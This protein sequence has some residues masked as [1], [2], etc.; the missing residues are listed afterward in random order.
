MCGIAG[1]IA[2]PDPDAGRAAVQRMLSRLTRRG[3]DAEGLQQWP[4]AVL[5]HRRLSIFDLS[6]AGR[7]PMTLP[8]GSVSVVFNGAIY[9]F[10]DLRQQL[11]AKGCHFHSRTDTEIL[12]HG[13]RVWGIEELVRRIR[14]MYAIGLWD[15]AERRLFLLRDRLGVKPLL[16]AERNGR[17]AFASTAPALAAAGF[18]G[19]IDPEA[20]SEYL[21]FGYVTDQRVIYSGLKKLLAGTVLE[22]QPGKGIVR[23]WRYWDLPPVDHSGASL[24]FETALARTEELLLDAVRLRLEADVPVGALLSG[25]I[26]SALVCWAI[27]KLGGAVTAFTVSTPGH[28]DDETEDARKTAAEIGI[29]HKIIPMR[30]EDEPSMDDLIQA[31]GEPFGCSSALGM[32]QVSRAVKQQATV[33]LTGDGGDD[34]FLGYPEHKHLLIAQRIANRIPGLVAKG[35]LAARDLVPRIGPLKRASNMLDYVSGG[36][37]AVACAHDGLPNYNGILGDRLRDATVDQRRIPWSPEAGRQVLEDFLRHDQK[38]RFPGEYMTKVDGGSMYHALEAR[39]PFLDAGLWSYAATLPFEVRLHGGRLKAL[40]REL[41]ARR[42]SY[43][44]AHGPKRGFVVPA[45]HWMTTRWKSRVSDAFSSSRLAAEGWI[46]GK[47]LATS[48]QSAQSAGR[49]SLQLWYLYV[50]EH[51]FRTADAGLRG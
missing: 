44:V 45:R 7:Q 51:W 4:K 49:A 38:T 22:F 46:D 47:S 37:G 33:L 17:L 16:Y 28:P 21:E 2:E 43:R 39:S 18:A 30:E 5:G 40:L 42:V 29:N 34:V 48:W 31:Y 41:A 36:V 26:D 27:T 24:D 32:I 3:P 1:L 50:L 8:D 19:P 10:L 12:L 6:D 25:G 9:N 14:G 23:Q 13:Y 20:L 15:A 35:W 11:E